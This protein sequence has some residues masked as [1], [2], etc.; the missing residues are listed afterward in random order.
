[1]SDA[2]SPSTQL[3]G[4]R[5]RDFLPEDVDSIVALGADFFAESEFPTFA[6]FAPDNFRMCLQEAVMSPSM[7]GLVFE[8]DREI[9]GFLFYQLDASYTKEPI[10]LMWLFYVAPDFRK[11]PVGRE[12]LHLA[13]NYAMAQGAVAFY[14][15]AMAGIPAVN[16]TLK[17]LYLKVGYEPLF[18]GRKTLK[19][20]PDV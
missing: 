18:W 7:T 4:P 3:T 12:L 20:N 5:F 11:S 19:G 17:N 16:T 2:S 9:K 1:M 15:G 6:T 10:A 8:Y 13:E 14:A